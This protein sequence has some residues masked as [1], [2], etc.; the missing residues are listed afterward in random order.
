MKQIIFGD[1]YSY[2]DFGLKLLEYTIDP[3]TVKKLSVDIPGGDGAVDLTEWP[4]YPVYNNRKASFAFDLQADNMVEMEDKLSN[5][6]ASLNGLKKEVCIGDGYYY[7]GR[8]SISTEPINNLFRMVNIEADFY[9]YKLKTFE[10]VESVT[11][12][13]EGASIEL[14]NELM[15]VVPKITAAKAVQ[16]QYGNNSFAVSA[17]EHY[18]PGIMLFQGKYSL[19]VKGSG[20]VT[21]TYREGRF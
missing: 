19:I 11:A 5:L 3:P 2:D 18:V 13:A 8:L 17:G 16:I 21:F 15:P 1:K 14:I 4:G 10:T 12:T 7:S 9:P 20:T 6:Y